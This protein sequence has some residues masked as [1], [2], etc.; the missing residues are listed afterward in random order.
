MHWSA[1]YVGIPFRD[2]GRDG[3][4]ADC[5]GLLR[6]VYADRLGIALPSYADDYACAT[7]AAEVA[8]LIAGERLVGWR[9]VAVAGEYDALLFRLGR[10]ET[11]VGVVIDHR[12]MLHMARETVSRVEN[13]AVSPWRHRFVGAFRWTGGAA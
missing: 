7:E 4:G 10:E 13:W 1:S 5:W 3:G 12:L 9:Q 11:H 2:R 6:L 8:A